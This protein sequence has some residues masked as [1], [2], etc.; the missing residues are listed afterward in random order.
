MSNFLLEL[1]TSIKNNKE[2]IYKLLN[3][4]N[5]ILNTN[6]TYEDLY[7]WL[8]VYIKNKDQKNINIIK[9]TLFIT[10]GLPHLTIQ[11]LDMISSSTNE[12]IIFINREFVAINKWLISEFKNI[13]HKNII[14]DIDNNYNK[15]INSN[16]YQVIPIGEQALINQVKEDFKLN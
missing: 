1:L 13:T 3:I 16:K 8:V 10:E 9:D 11:I 4:D 12:N 14:L 2:K 6:I 7:N 5:S 15:Y